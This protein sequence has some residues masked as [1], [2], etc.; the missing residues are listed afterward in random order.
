M[1]VMVGWAVTVING[2][3]AHTDRWPAPAG[4]YFK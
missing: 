4:V 3:E 1:N 2:K